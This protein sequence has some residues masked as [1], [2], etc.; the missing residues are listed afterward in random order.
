MPRRSPAKAPLRGSHRI[1]IIT[2]TSDQSIILTVDVKTYFSSRSQQADV[3]DQLSQIGR[4]LKKRWE[5][6]GISSSGSREVLLEPDRESFPW[7]FASPTQE[8]LENDGFPGSSWTDNGQR[9]DEFDSL[10]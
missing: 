9:F 8:E 6:Q 4:V 3:K 1:N 7:D 5:A 2:I 10:E